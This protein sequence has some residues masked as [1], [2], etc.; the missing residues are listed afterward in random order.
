MPPRDR[1]RANAARPAFDYQQPPR[2]S[3][4]QAGRALALAACLAVSAGDRRCPQQGNG[5][6]AEAATRRT[7]RRL[8]LLRIPVSRDVRPTRVSRDSAGNRKG[9]AVGSRDTDL[10]HLAGA[11][12]AE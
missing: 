11:A 10:A 2:N 5:A 4:G 7:A 12:G 8:R 6:L 3:G 9:T 1:I